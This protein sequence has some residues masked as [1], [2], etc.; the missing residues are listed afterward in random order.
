MKVLLNT[1]RVVKDSKGKDWWLDLTQE[2]KEGI[3]K[4]LRDIDAGRTTPHDVVRKKYG[5]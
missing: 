2:Q 3:E 1:L 5:L 4:G